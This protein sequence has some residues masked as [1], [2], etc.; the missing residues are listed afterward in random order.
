MPR[1]NTRYARLGCRAGLYIV[2]GLLIKHSHVLAAESTAVVDDRLISIPLPESALAPDKPS[3]AAELDGYDISAFSSLNGNMLEIRLKTPLARGKHSLNVSLFLADGEI[4]SVAYQDFYVGAAEESAGKLQLNTTFSSNYLIDHDQRHDY[5]SLNKHTDNGAVELN[6]EQRWGAFTLAADAK[7]IYDSSSLNNPDHENWALP[8]YH[9]VSTYQRNDMAGSLG[10]GNINIEQE[11]LLFSSFQRRGVAAELTGRDSKYQLKAFGVQSGA[12]SRIDRELVTSSDSTKQNVGMTAG[13]YLPDQ[14]LRL[15]TGYISGETRLG[16]AGSSDSAETP[17]YGGDSWNLAID[18]VWL[19]NSLWMHLEYAQSVFDSDG[20]DIGMSEERDSASQAVLRLSSDG[21]LGGGWFDTW[22]GTLQYKSVGKDF[23]SLGNLYLPGDSKLTRAFFQ[24]ASGAIGIE[25]ELA[26]EQ[27]NID[28]DAYLP[29]QMHDQAGIT[30]NYNPMNLNPDDVLWRILGSPS[31]TARYYRSHHHQPDDDALLAGYDL[32]NWVN[33]SDL[34]LNFSHP[35]WSWGLHY[36]L[37]D[38][39]DISRAVAEGD[40]LIY[41]PPS[42]QHNTLVAL[43]LG[44]MPSE[45]ASINLLLQWNKR[46]EPDFDNT[47][48][49][50]NLGFDAAVQLVPETLSLQVNYNYSGDHSKLSDVLAPEDD[51]LNHT[52]STQ[53]LWHAIKASGVNPAID[54]Y[55]RGSYGKQDNR[56]FAIV[57]EQWN[58]NFG[59]NIKWAAGGQE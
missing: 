19:K 17:I 49:S 13:I 52:A 44:F 15:S 37:F 45:W 47:Y 53:L 5:S 38:Q 46:H 29:T 11:S 32:D 18:S 10:V 58:A 23:Y 35:H 55:F 34:N 16:N 21:D 4:E 33:E 48:R 31:V 8:E 50:R 59:L 57:D 26:R 2:F 36:N 40:Y 30:I 14:R 3:I 6:G 54:F 56:T 41:Q 27:S 12:S 42:D 1:M 7:A 28:N 51:F 9:M 24:S 22:S 43:Q 25:T 39:D 20:L